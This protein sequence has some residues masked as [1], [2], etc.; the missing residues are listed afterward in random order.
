M[1][2]FDVN[3]MSAQSFGSLTSQSATRVID[4]EGVAA[5]AGAIVRDATSKQRAPAMMVKITLM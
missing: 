3:K 5:W 2:I 1:T 4:W